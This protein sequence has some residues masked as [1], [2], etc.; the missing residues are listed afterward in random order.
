MVVLSE[1]RTK[2]T[3]LPLMIPSDYGLSREVLAALVQVLNYIARQKE[4]KNDTHR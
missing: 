1:L 2:R 3:L 4:E